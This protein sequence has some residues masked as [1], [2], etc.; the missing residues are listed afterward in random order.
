MSLEVVLQR[1]QRRLYLAR[2]LRGAVWGAAGGAGLALACALLRLFAVEPFVALGMAP[3]FLPVGLGGLA[4]A[5]LG[6]R[7]RYTPRTA[8]AVLEH[9]TGRG[10]LFTTALELDPSHPWAASVQGEVEAAL[11]ADAQEGPA[12]AVPFQLP[13]RAPGILGLAALLTLLVALA[14]PLQR[15]NRA[16]ARPQAVLDETDLREVRRLGSRLRRASDAH[17]AGALRQASEDLERFAR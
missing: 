1:V 5:L 2:V 16:D 14:P 9:G 7:R 6:L 10:A 15:V 8:A 4:G 3:L 17:E 13:A 11:A 12:R